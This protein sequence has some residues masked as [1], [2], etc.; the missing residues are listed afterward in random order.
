M[1]ENIFG[2]LSAVFRV[3]RKPMLLEPDNASLVVMAIVH[4]HNFLLKKL[5]ILLILDEDVQGHV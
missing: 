4:L 2:I 5:R 3:L 1:V